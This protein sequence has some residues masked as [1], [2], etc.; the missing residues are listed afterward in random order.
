[1]RLI[2]AY[3][4]GNSSFKQ[5]KSYCFRF[6]PQSVQEVTTSNITAVLILSFTS[7]SSTEI[8]SAIVINWS[9]LETE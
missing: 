8:S 7:T 9:R 2:R 6:G 5:P 4:K 3:L 1:M